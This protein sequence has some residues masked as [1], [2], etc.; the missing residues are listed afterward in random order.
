MCAQLV[1]GLSLHC[2]RE[3]VGG[4][5]V[6]RVTPLSIPL[7]PEERRAVSSNMVEGGL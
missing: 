5:T 7:L 6:A 2:E 4:V 1:L 3:G